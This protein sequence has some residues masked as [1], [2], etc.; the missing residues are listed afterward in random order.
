M[1]NGEIP[2]DESFLGPMIRD[3]CHENARGYLA[4]PTS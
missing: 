1:E 2:D 4:L 3:I